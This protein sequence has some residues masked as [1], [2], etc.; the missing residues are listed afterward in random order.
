MVDLDDVHR[1]LAIADEALRR[2][3]TQL[4]V[5]ADDGDASVLGETHQHLEK[6]LTLVAD[7]EANVVYVQRND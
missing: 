7:C 4:S 6:A 1:Q 3:E 2:A 5:Y